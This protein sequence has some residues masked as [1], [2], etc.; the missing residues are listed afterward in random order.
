M[1]FLIESTKIILFVFSLTNLLILTFLNLKISPIIMLVKY[2][3]III[4]IASIEFKYKVLNNNLIYG[5]IKMLLRRKYA[6]RKMHNGSNY[7]VIMI[8]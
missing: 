3:I 1:V 8:P 5:K 4:L 7:I 2:V 6:F